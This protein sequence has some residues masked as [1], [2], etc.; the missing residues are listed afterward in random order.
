VASSR[1]LVVLGTASQEPTRTRNHNGYLFHLDDVHLLVDPGEGTQRQMTLAGTSTA[2]LSGVLVTHFHGDHCLGLPGV[3]QRRCLDRPDHPL[4]LWF[5]ASGAVYLD[6]L[7]HATATDIPLDR[8]VVRHPVSEEG[9]VGRLGRFTITAR[10]LHHPVDV[11]GYRLEEPPRTHL[12]PDAL[13]R[14][15]VRGRAVGELQRYGSVVVDGRPLHVSEVSYTSPGQVV[16]VVLDTSWCDAAV[17]LAR[18]ADLLL[19]EATYAEHEADLAERYGHLTAAQA[20]R[21]ARAAGA[22][23]LVITHFSS[24]YHDVE[25]LVREAAAEFPTVVAARDLERIPLPP[26]LRQEGASS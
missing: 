8:E 13:A 1:E 9:E 17:E 15:G 11:V 26:I 20:G 14:A 23:F 4:P 16:A 21:M 2:H 18:G 12:S 10:R 6:R 24:R 5:P 3:V 25:V 22:R 7:L 19:C